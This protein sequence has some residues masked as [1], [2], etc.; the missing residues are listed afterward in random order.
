[1]HIKS[2]EDH[3]IMPRSRFEWD[4][5]KAEANRAKHGVAF[6]EAVTAFDDPRG[7]EVY[8]DRRAYGEDRWVWFGRVSGRLLVVAVAYT[9]RGNRLRIIS[10]RPAERDEERAYYEG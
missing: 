2:K 3:R 1:M 6:E 10:A 8:D 5:A 7:F 9:E 4:E